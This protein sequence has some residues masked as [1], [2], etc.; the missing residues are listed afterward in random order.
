[1]RLLALQEEGAPA[2]TGQ[3]REALE[4]AAHFVRPDG[5][6]FAGAAAAR[7]FFRY[8]PGGWAVV[9]MARFPGVMP[10]AERLYRWV[11]RR[12]GPVS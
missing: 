7:E 12:W 6:V 3:P 4:R 11:A 8:V 1:V 10:A 2:I 9:G 5:E